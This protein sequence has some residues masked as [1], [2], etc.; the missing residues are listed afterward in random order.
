MQVIRAKTAGFCMGV[1]RALRMLD[2]ALEDRRGNNAEGRLC[3]LGPIIHNPRLV[4]DYEE[5]GAACLKDPDSA[6]P[7]DTLVIRAHGLPRTLEDALTAKGARLVDATCPKVKSAQLAIKRAHES[8]KG[9]LLLFGELDHPEVQGLLSYAGPDAAVFG[10]LDELR[11]LPL[12]PG[13]KYFLAAQTTQDGKV[14]KEA[15]DFLAGFLGGRPHVLNTICAATRERQEDL[16]R[17]AATVRS[18]VI[19]GGMNSGNT[20]RLAEISSALGVFTVHCEDASSLPLEK[21]AGLQPV[22]LS[23][24]ASTPDAHID[25]IEKVLLEYIV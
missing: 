7:G 11:S 25:A 16:S 4:R 21:L 12:K 19:V 2:A 22:G 20:R 1:S 6:V 23:A 24:G 5:A 3:T 9:R 18:M 10:S 17:L 15:T 8:G 13:G 14:F